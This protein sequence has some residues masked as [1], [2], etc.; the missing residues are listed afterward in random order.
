M[1]IYSITSVDKVVKL[2]IFFQWMRAQTNSSFNISALDSHVFDHDSF[3]VHSHPINSSPPSAIYMCQWIRSTLVQIM[4]CRLFGA[5]PLSKP[6][7]GYCQ[8]GPSKKMS[9]IFESKYKTFHSQKCIWK[10]CEMEAIFVGEMGY[11]IGPGRCGS[12]HCTE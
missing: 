2:M 6:M 10:C 1:T 11:F 8:L 12:N 3:S 4:A 5:K 9:V 7:E